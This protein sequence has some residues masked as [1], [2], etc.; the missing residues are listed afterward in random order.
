MELADSGGSTLTTT[1][2]PSAD[3]LTLLPKPTSAVDVCT[4]LPEMLRRDLVGRLPLPIK[5]RS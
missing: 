3:R 4:Q 2:T 1:G 5:R